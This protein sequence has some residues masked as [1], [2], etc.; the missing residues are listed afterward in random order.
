MSRI[1]LH[2][3]THKTATTHIQDLFFRNSDLLAKHGIVY[4]EIGLNRGHHGLLGKWVDLPAPYGLPQADAAMAWDAIVGEHAV[5]DRTVFLSSEEF[6]RLH[7]RIVDMAALAATVAPFDDVTVLCTLRNQAGFVQSVYQQIADDRAPMEWDAFLDRAMQ[8]QHVDGLTLNYLRLHDHFLSGFAPDQIR[9]LSYEVASAGPGGI[10]GAILRELGAPIG[11]DALEPFADGRSNVSV[12][13]VATLA[14]T[15]IAAPKRADRAL[16]QRVDDHVRQ[17]FGGERTS[18]FSAEEV[19]ALD[20]KY[21]PLN[22][23]LEARLAPRQ[24]DFRVAPVSV[25]PATVLRD[26][27]DEAFWLPFCRDLAGLA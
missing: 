2:V 8:A 24:P 10:V 16:M 13:P 20:A 5:S 26:R 23:R 3:G 27:M 25:A 4:P 6:S 17:V 22:R 7:G 9:F 12:A 15:L 19:S 11:A 1:V 14:A 18:L 21:S